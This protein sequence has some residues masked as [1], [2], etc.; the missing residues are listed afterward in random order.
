[1]SCHHDDFLYFL[2]QCNKLFLKKD[3]EDKLDYDLCSV[4]LIKLFIL[5]IGM[6]VI[7]KRA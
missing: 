2:N 5:L 6:V 7:F 1:M 3:L 4:Q